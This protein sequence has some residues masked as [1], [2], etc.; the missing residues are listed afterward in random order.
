MTNVLMISTDAKIFEEGSA[1]RERMREYG[2]LFKELHIIVFVKKARGCAPFAMDNVK[3]YPTNSSS[4]LFYVPNAINLGALIIKESALLGE[5]CVITTQDPFETGYVGRAL[6]KK[7]SLPLHVQIHTDF[8]NPYFVRG[9]GL[10]IIRAALAKKNLQAAS[11]IR[12]VSERIRESIEGNEA[13]GVDISD[14]SVLPI[15]TDL[16]SIKETQVP[17]GFSQ[18]YL[19]SDK[20]ALIA[21]RFTIEKDIETAIDAFARVVMAYPKALLVIIGAGPEEANLHEKVAK[22]RIEDNVMIESWASREILTSYL[23]TADVFV[24]SSLYEGYGLSML[25]A[26]VAGAQIVA[27]DAGIARDLTDAVCPPKSPDCLASK[28]VSVF[29]GEKVNREFKYEYKSKEAYLEAFKRDIE[30]ALA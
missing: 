20:I 30:R 12:A 17:I 6:S 21:S 1:V 10:N 23:K 27:T 29:S 5:N 15:Y 22:L 24:S 28:I 9:G 3:V 2:K 4:K 8:L 16:R 11:A 13:L 18:R 26:H 19:G 14:V 25:E 7:F